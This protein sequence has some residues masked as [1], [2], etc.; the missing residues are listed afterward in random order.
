MKRSFVLF[1][2]S[3]TVLAALGVVVA[4]D[5]PKKTS[6]LKHGYAQCIIGKNPPPVPLFEHPCKPKPVAELQCGEAVD[7]ARREGP[8]LVIRTAEGAEQYV[9][10]LSVSL[11][12]KKFVPV[13]LPE[14]AG[15]H[16]EDCTF[17]Q[18]THYPVAIYHPDP[19]YPEQGDVA[20]R[21][22]APY[23]WRLP[24]VRTE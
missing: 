9:G 10:V 24:S 17:L 11:S 5:A 1:A 14:G 15:P 7:V 22:R 12:K 18:P 13:E 3:L 8:W 19:E 4:D 21:S 20:P 2:T 23:S 16:V 6:D